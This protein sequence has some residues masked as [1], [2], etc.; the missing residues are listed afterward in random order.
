MSSI[1]HVF[2]TVTVN[3]VSAALAYLVG[4]SLLHPRPAAA[5]A[6]QKPM[7]TMAVGPSWVKSGTPRFVSKI[8]P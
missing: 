7:Q 2:L 8:A 1:V 5:V 6:V 3:V 4:E